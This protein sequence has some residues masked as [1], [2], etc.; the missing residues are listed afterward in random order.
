MNGLTRDWKK[1]TR[2]N[3][4]DSCVEARAHDGGAQIR[5]SKDRSGPV[6]SFDRASYGHFLT[7]LR[8]RRQAVLADVAMR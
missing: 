8:A 5:D 2:S 7:G 3:G 4:S 6:L 1:S